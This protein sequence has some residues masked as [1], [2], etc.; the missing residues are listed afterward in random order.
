MKKIRKIVAAL[1][2]AAMMCSP[3]QMF[4]GAVD[5]PFDDSQLDGFTRIE[6]G[7]Y[8]N[9]EP[10]FAYYDTDTVYLP[11]TEIYVS[12]TS[13]SL[14][15]KFSGGMKLNYR[16]SDGANAKD[17][18]E[19]IDSLGLTSAHIITHNKEYSR[20][21]FYGDSVST[22][23]FKKAYRAL[24]ESS[25]ISET[26]VKFVSAFTIIEFRP[27]CISDDFLS[28]QTADEER[29]EKYL[30]EKEIGFKKEFIYSEPYENEDNAAVCRA[31][32]FIPEKKMTQLEKLA[33]FD[34]IYKVLVSE[35]T[36]AV[37]RYTW[38]HHDFP[39]YSGGGINISDYTDG[40]ANCDDKVTVADAVAVLQYIA[41]KE[42]YPLSEQAQFNADIDG[43]DGITGGDAMA[44]QKIDAGI[45]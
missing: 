6:R 11:G 38:G 30:T 5:I 16:L 41:N 37:Y 36:D 21:A 39:D 40:D 45:M 14:K 18:E 2:G 28:F 10:I 29:V 12:D 43:E 42:K 13:A 23:E 31:V 26:A 7:Q 35:D 20:L 27:A 9:L 33:L 34:E 1:M 32:R 24:K 22:S 17:A 4:S 3:I 25:F 19:L 15:I 8:D 44:I